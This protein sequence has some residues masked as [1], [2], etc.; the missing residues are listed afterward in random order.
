MANSTILPYRYLG[1]SGL[2]VSAICLGTMTFGVGEV[3]A[4]P[5]AR[6]SVCKVRAHAY[7]SFRA[8]GCVGG[9]GSAALGG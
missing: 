4:C 5:H 9:V 2:K 8:W 3:S 6:T 1:N 7:A